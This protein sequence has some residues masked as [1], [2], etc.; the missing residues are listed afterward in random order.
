MIMRML[1]GCSNRS[2]TRGRKRKRTN[3]NLFSL[4]KIVENQCESMNALSTKRRSL[5]LARIKRANLDIENRN[6]RV[7]GVH[8]IA[9]SNPQDINRLSD[10]GTNNDFTQGHVPSRAEHRSS[11]QA[12]SRASTKRPCAT[13]AG[14]V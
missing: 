7:C 4:P 9:E 2:D 14:K 11:K 5:W 6:L 13:S 8:F 1:F 12:R 10:Y 3:G